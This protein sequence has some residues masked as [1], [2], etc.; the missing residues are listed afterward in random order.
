MDILHAAGHRGLGFAE[1][2]RDRR[3]GRFKLTEVTAGRMWFR[4][5]LVT[6]SGINLPL[7][8]YRDLLGLPVEA[9]ATYVHEV[10]PRGA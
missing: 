9:P 7:I 1:F 10:D 6:R 8:M 3:D 2:K 5:G 4:H